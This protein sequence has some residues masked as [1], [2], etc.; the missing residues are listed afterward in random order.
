[1]HNRICGQNEFVTAG[2]MEKRYAQEV[3]VAAIRKRAEATMPEEGFAQ[4][5]LKSGGLLYAYASKNQSRSKE[6]SPA[7]FE[8]STN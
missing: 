1:M 4:A 5:G 8:L 7:L 2:A 6:I 3:Y